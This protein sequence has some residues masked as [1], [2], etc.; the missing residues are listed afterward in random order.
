M[1]KSKIA[2]IGLGDMGMGHFNGFSALKEA[3]VTAVCDRDQAAIARAFETVKGST[4]RQYTDY[5]EMLDKEAVDG[6]VIAVPGYLHEETAIE[7]IKRGINVF[8]EKPVAI[9]YAGYKNILEAKKNSKSIIQVGL[10]YRYSNFYR[11]ISK[12]LNQQ[13]ELGNVMMAWCKEFRQCFPQEEWFYDETRS[14][15]TIVEK[16][17][18][19]FDIFNWMIGS[20]PKSVFAMGGQH[21]YKNGQDNLIDCSYSIKDP[22]IIRD[23][24]I[25]DHA[26]V[27]VEYEN[28]AKAQLGLCMYLR[29]QN[30]SGD[31][32]EVG[33]IGDNGKQLIARRDECFGIYGG[34]FNDKVEYSPDIISDNNGFG[35][36]GCQTQRLEFI[37]CVQLNRQPVASIEQTKDALL[38][39]LAAEKSIKEGRLVSLEE[40]R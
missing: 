7:C 23:V 34:E 6:V 3:Q 33:F 15:G 8:L 27:T 5:R 20:R 9:D 31:G 16:D 26:F 10:V 25:V 36:I 40:Y 38:I 18:H 17:C 32:L 1:N 11:T 22:K 37:E 28:G 19:H 30:N 24:S 12:M 13:K 29:P 2:I 39:A 21:V 35:H 14:G 4:A